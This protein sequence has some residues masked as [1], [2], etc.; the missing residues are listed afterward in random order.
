MALRAGVAL[1]TALVIAPPAQA[2]Q[3]PHTPVTLRV[4]PQRPDLV[5]YNRVEALSL[6]VRGQVRPE[7]PWGPLSFTGTFRLGIADLH[8]NGVLEVFHESVRDRITVRG[9][10]ELTSIDEDARD[11]GLANSLMALLAG[12]ALGDYYRRSGATVEVTPPTADPRTFRVRVFAEHQEGVGKETDVQLP[13]LWDDVRRFR[14]NI[15]AQD[16]WELGSSLELTR[17]WGRDPS[18][19]R[20]GV[21]ATV[22]AATGERDFVRSSIGSDVTVALPARLSVTL[23][24]EGG[25]SWGTPSVQRL[26]YLGGPL[27]LHGFEPRA[28]GGRSFTR[29]RAEL[30]RAFSFGHVIVFSDVGWAG[31]RDA[32]DL[33][34]ALWSAGAGLALIDGILRIDGAWPIDDPRGFRVDVYLDQLL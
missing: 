12:Q 7:T 19:T 3:L 23:E 24:A 4:A 6:G 28:L 33:D 2:Q 10:H 22:L 14:A 26:W 16:G 1:L 5:R 31:D 30:E 25:T 8:P 17:R 34:D 13:R 29:G 11:F 15:A 27:T 18:R 20:G 32:F 9:Y 21:G